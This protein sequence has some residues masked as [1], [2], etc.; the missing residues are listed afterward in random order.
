MAKRKQ[1]ATETRSLEQAR[2]ALDSAVAHS[3]TVLARVDRVAPLPQRASILEIGSAQGLFLIACA[4]M[5][6]DAIGV[7]PWDQAREV[8]ARLAQEEGVSISL[9]DG[10]A[11]QIPAGDEECDVIFAN[12]VLEHADDAQ[13]VFREVYRVLRPGGAFWFSSASSLCPRQREIRGFP[14]FGWYPNRLKLHIMAWAKDH[15]PELVG[16]TEHPAIN[17]F[18]PWKARRM[19]REAGFRK[20]HDRWDLRLPTEG[21]RLAR[22]ALRVGRSC[23]LTK[24]AG[25]IVSQGCSYAAVK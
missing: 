12:S 22:L 9:R 13:A 1:Q 15:R 19:L 6:H 10:V 24:L 18:T 11:E 4:R 17:W 16:H 7:E 14:L 3:R 8:A 20:I 25:D 21:G 2:A 5:G 23:R